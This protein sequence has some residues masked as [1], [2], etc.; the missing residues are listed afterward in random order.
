M[1]PGDYVCEYVA[2]TDNRGNTSLIAAPGI[3]F[4]VEGSTEEREGPALVDW[5][6]A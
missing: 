1:P 3:E 6:F 4:H 2:L 5:S